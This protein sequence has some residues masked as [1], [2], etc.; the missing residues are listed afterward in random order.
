VALALAG[1]V[2]HQPGIQGTQSLR[3]EVLAPSD[4]G[5]PDDRLDDTQL[6]VTVR[7]SARDEQNELDTEFDGEV[8]VYAQ[9]LGTLTPTLD[10]APLDRVTLSG[11][12]SAATDIVLPPVYGPTLL[13]VEDG[14]GDDATFATGTSDTLWYRDP[15][16]ADLSRPLDEMA[17][18]AL[19]SSPLQDKQVTVSSSRYGA[20]GRLVVTAVTAQGYTVSDCQCGP[21][22]APP[23]TTG[24]YDHVLVFSFSRPKDER[25]RNIELGHVLDGFGGGVSEFNGLTEIAFPQTFVESDDPVIDPD[26]VPEPF[27]IQ[28]SFLTDTIEMER[29]E[30]ALVAVDGAVLCEL[31]EDWETYKQWKLDIGA[32]CGSPINVIT[33]GIVEFDPADYVGMTIPRVVGSLRP[34]NIGSFNVWIMYPRFASDL[35]LP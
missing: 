19:E 25:G 10:E 11:G 23:C 21:G 32:G 3:V 15:F 14:S 28:E 5:S 18:D 2:D 27:L 1:C 29:R 35:E 22:G 12:E 34:V 7:I 30:S 8:D 17:L 31:D 20:D 4:L 6:G 26:L 9:F 24:D 33:A 16:A 13:W